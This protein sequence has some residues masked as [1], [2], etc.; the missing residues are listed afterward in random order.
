MYDICPNTDP[1]LIGLNALLNA[2][3]PY[4][5]WSGCVDSLNQFNCVTN[6]HFE[7]PLSTGA[8][9]NPTDLPASGTQALTN[10]AGEITSPASGSVFS[11]TAIGQ[12]FTVTALSINAFE[13]TTTSQNGAANTGGAGTVV[14]VT[15]ATGTSA[16]SPATTAKS[17]AKKMTLGIPSL[18]AAVMLCGVMVFL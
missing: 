15:G 12:E 11:Y 9:Y 2:V 3:A 1:T 17:G 13:A 8:V 14:G 18:L 16:G 5:P 6:L 10:I 7:A 4:Y